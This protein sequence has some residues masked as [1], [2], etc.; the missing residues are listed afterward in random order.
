MMSLSNLAVRFGAV[1]LYTSTNSEKIDEKQTDLQNQR[2]EFGK[3]PFIR[4]RLNKGKA[5]LI[6]ITGP[7]RQGMALLSLGLTIP[8]GYDR[9]NISDTLLE[10][11]LSQDTNIRNAA[12]EAQL[13]LID[14]LFDEAKLKQAGFDYLAKCL[15]DGTTLENQ[16]VQI[17]NLQA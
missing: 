1:T 7:D 5:E 8:E 12:N 10:M 13:K 3:E 2:Y 15:A 6:E 17:I 16:P 14:L 9:G 4:S 11:N